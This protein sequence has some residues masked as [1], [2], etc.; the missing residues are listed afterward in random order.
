M[1][2]KIVTPPKI[3]EIEIK[4]V[5]EYNKIK[6]ILEKSHYFRGQCNAKW[7]LESTLERAM[8]KNLFKPISPNIKESFEKELYQITKSYLEENKIQYNT[9]LNVQSM[10]QHYGGKT[11]LL[12]FTSDMDIALFFAIFSNLEL[13]KF[14]KWNGVIWAIN[15]IDS[16]F[17]SKKISRLAKEDQYNSWNFFDSNYLK[18]VP[19]EFQ[20]SDTAIDDKAHIIFDAAF[21][22]SINIEY[23]NHE[24]GVPRIFFYCP[25][26]SSKCDKKWPWTSRIQVQKGLFLFPLDFSQSISKNLSD[27]KDH[28][29]WKKKIQKI[30]INIPELELKKLINQPKSIIRIILRKSKYSELKAEILGLKITYSKL[31]PELEPFIR[32]NSNKIINQSKSLRNK[33]G[34]VK[35][36]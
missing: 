22:N 16:L 24:S 23:L 30:D 18:S 11:R 21:N 15:K 5:P 13:E 1:Y 3:F 7:N 4:S 36:K 19:L 14:S 28:N 9:I 10:I 20:N 33:V 26:F 25:S 35:T 27:G 32:Y 2:D 12:D 17:Q 29:Y 31:F 34:Q 6:E 8:G